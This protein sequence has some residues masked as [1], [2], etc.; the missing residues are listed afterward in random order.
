MHRNAR[1]T[2]AIA[3]GTALRRRAARYLDL[4]RKVHPD[5][6][7][8]PS[9]WKGSLLRSVLFTSA[10][11]MSSC[12]G[13]GGG[14]A[15][16]HINA[17]VV[18]TLAGTGVAGFNNGA[19]NV[20][21]LDFPRGAAIDSAGN[22]YVAD[23][24]NHSIRKI[25]A[26]GVV[27]TLAG[28]GVA[29]FDNG[30][31][32]VATFNSPSGVAIDGTGNVYVVDTG[33][34]SI[35][36][37]APSDVVSTFAGTGVAGFDNGAGNVA[38]FSSPQ[39]VATDSAGNVY[40]GDTLNHSIRKI[41][42]AGVVS[43]LA[44]TGVAGFDNGNGNVAT[45]N[46]PVG[47]ATDSAGNVYVADDSNNSVRKITPAGVVSTLAGTGVA[48]FNNGAGNVA[49]FHFPISVATDSAGNI[50]VADFSNHSIRKI[51]SSG[52]VS[53]LAGTTGAPGFI[54]GAGSVAAF[55][56]PEG[57]ATDSVGNVY[58]ADTGNNSIR[59][60]Q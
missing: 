23:T 38:T 33:N 25:T 27:S 26:A 50:F 60:I 58:V 34:N 1:L 10:L 42:A 37:I 31:G 19:G 56:L 36:K 7:G 16:S 3:V 8:S 47:V 57:V 11:L 54:D 13:G 43:T 28:T 2:F 24:S 41:T 4:Q 17:G 40:V 6:M 39:G 14:G 5:A 44:G 29:G 18:S 53:T 52:T 15:G 9:V 12:G 21:T 48:G 55:N 20:A 49:T 22:V 35:R 30:A 46:F 32:N 59:K 51:D 45:F